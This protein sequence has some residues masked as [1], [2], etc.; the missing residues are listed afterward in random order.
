MT[1]CF[2]HCGWYRWR[3]VKQSGIDLTLA[4]IK[5]RTERIGSHGEVEQDEDQGSPR[6]IGTSPDGRRGSGFPIDLVRSMGKPI[7]AKARLQMLVPIGIVI[8]FILLYFTFHSAVEASMVMLS[9]PFALVGGVYLVSALG[10]NLSV[11][12]RVG[13][14][15][16]YGIAVE[17]GVAMAL[18]AYSENLSYSQA[19]SIRQYI[20]G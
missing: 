20:A 9:V 14:I 16:L 13:F 4:G 6:P 15:A 5:Q 19:D 3:A 12:V 18:A 1:Q 11:A 17:T 8:I 7:C 2:C 10:Y